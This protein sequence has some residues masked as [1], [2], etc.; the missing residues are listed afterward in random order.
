LERKQGG[1]H[2]KV[3]KEEQEGG[4]GVIIVSKIKEKNLQINQVKK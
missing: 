2:G 4:N 3:W 1:L